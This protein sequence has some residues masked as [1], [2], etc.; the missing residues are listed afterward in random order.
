MNIS[1]EPDKNKTHEN[2]LQNTVLKIECNEQ[3]IYFS[4]LHK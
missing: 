1:I 4:L 2:L 3:F